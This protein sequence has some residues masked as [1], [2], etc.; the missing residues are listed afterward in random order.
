MT[1]TGRYAAGW[2]QAAGV[3]VTICVGKHQRHNG[4]DS[5]GHRKT[6]FL[7][8]ILKKLTIRGDLN[9]RAL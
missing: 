1:A 6:A 5:F 2:T 7:H 8:L 3:T 9:S 4:G